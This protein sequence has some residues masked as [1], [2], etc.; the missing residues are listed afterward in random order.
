M[1]KYKINISEK[2]H[3]KDLESL[4]SIFMPIIKEMASSDDFIATEIMLKWRDIAGS[5]IASYTRPLKTKYNPKTEERTLYME[6]PLG[7]YALEIQ[8]KEKYLTDKINA[9]FGYNAIHKLNIAQN[10]NMQLT[11]I[12]KQD[13]KNKE[14]IVSS[15]DMNYLK[16]VT[17]EIKDENLRKVLINIGKNIMLNK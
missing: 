3:E 12:E 15:E 17:K 13:D 1:K 11:E 4:G 5:E 7:G 16:S 6:V 2:R 10:A 14:K 9:Y 8:H